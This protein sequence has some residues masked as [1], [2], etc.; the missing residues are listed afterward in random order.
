METIKIAI[1][2]DQ[3]LFRKAIAEVIKMSVDIELLVDAD[4]GF[5]LM[6]EMKN[7]PRLPDIV[8]IDLEMPI[9]NGLQLNEQLQL[10]YPSIKKIV[11]SVFNQGKFITRMID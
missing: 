11:L 2:D 3:L 6:E 5:L 4:N 8:L 10:H 9:M 7:M 1:A